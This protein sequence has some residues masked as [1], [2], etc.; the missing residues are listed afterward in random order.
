MNENTKRSI[1]LPLVLG[2]VLAGGIL[3]GSR[4][5]VPKNKTS[6][7]KISDILDFIQQ[8]YV[9]TINR[10]QI[11]D[12]S[13]VKILEQLD[14]H[15]AYIPASELEASNEPLEGN[16]EGVGIEFHL[17][18]D[19]I[20]V[21]SAIA[22]G[23]S[24]QA[25]L[26][27]GDRIVEVDEKKIVGKGI[28]NEK[29]MKLLRGKGGS[30]VKV[31][32][33]R[34]GHN[35]LM[36]FTITRGKIPIYSIEVA[37]M[38]NANTG[39]IKISRFGATT[40][41]EFMKAAYNL[42]SQ[43]MKQMIIDL[44]GNPGGYLDAAT[45]ISDEFLSGE[46]LIVYTEGKARPR[47]D[48]KAHTDGIFETGKVV[49]LIDEGSASAAEIL[50]GALQDWDRATIVGRRSFGKGLVQEQTTLP[51]GSAIRLTIAR[52]YTPTGRCIQKPYLNGVDAYEEE[53]YDRVKHGE[54]LS[55][56]SIHF[57]DSLKFKTPNGNI[58]YGGGGIM[59]DV[60]VPVDTTYESDY[61]YKIY[62]L[63]IINQFAIEYD[64]NNRKILSSYKSAID[65][66]KRFNV[67]DKMLSAFIAFAEKSGVKK[68]EAGI[69]RSEPLIKNQLKANIARIKWQNEGLY[70]ILQ[71][72]DIPLK[73]G[74]ELLK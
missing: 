73:K 64:D 26:M 38:I 45:S 8:E 58:V 25:G 34:R 66:Q 19:S 52:Y 17:Q 35:S 46:K 62:G 20:M 72:F 16:F 42:D 71:D 57:N 69:K 63:G 4:L 56:D 70:P 10:E 53:L 48:Y 41:D 39:Y 28:N 11:I 74:L 31:G 68:N 27:A 12:K 55:K 23:P 5:V 22:G 18:D 43:G 37:Y 15:S 9:D 50:S 59:P 49:V 36:P 21:V 7:N 40:Y 2:V 51:D 32:I 33:Y 14:P 13:I 54:L 65:Y 3:I 29:V 61:L 30:K 60:F 6:Y 24:E 47:T 44:R 67:D 1:L